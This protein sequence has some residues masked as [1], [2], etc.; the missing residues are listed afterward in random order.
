[1]PLLHEFFD[2]AASRWPDRVAIEVPAGPGR[3]RQHLTYRD[4]DGRASHLGVRLGPL[5]A[6][7]PLV[8][9]LMARDS[10]WLV[11]AQLAALRRGAAFASL[12]P[13]FPDGQIRAQ[14][15]DAEPA[16]V[17]VDAASAARLRRLGLTR[18]PLVDVDADAVPA[19]PD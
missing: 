7:E 4:L 10:P 17:V 18:W 8:A 3:P 16:A 5:A 6:A 1:M 15:A 19:V 12:D 9:I 11:A 2:R 14:L 13:A